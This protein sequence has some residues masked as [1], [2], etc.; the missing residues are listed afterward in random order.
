[1]ATV[2]EKIT[3]LT[4]SRGFISQMV[5]AI[6][7]L[8][9]TLLGLSVSTTQAL[10]CSFSFRSKHERTAGAEHARVTVPTRFIKSSLCC[11]HFIQVLVGSISGVALSS[12]ASP[13]SS[14]ASSSSSSSPSTSSSSSSNEKDH[15][16]AQSSNL[17]MALVKKIAVSWLI[18]MP[19]SAF[20]SAVVF[21]FC[22]GDPNLQ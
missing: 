18:T 2:G 4:F 8:G 13:S 3:K 1:M 11:L 19:A 20:C 7:V 17:N 14:A 16:H 6:L 9:A 15:P 22:R 5:T 10:F 21:A 12:D